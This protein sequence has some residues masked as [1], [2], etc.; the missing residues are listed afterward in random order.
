MADFEQA[1]AVVLSH[2]GGFVDNP[3]D[4]GGATKYGISLRFLREEMRRNVRPIDVRQM[5]KDEA[6]DIYREWW[7]DR[8]GYGAIAD[9]ATATKVF[10][11]AVNMGGKRAHRIVQEAL[12]DLGFSLD[13]DGVLG[14]QTCV[15]I[16]KTEPRRLLSKLV[17]RQSDYYRSLA[18]ARPQFRVFLAGWLERAVWPLGTKES[19]A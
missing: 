3:N 6:I 10:D 16:A 19:I 15:A 2:E 11:M 5:T 13:V 12:N 1:V 17:A 18:Q 7:W 4:P 14:A 9:Q 8:F